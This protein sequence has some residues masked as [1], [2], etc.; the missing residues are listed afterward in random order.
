VTYAAVAVIL[1]VV[2][3]GATCAP[4]RRAVRIDPLVALRTE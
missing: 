2:A 4:L 1:A 3:I